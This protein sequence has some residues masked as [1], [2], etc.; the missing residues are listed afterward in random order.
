MKHG[1]WVQLVRAGHLPNVRCYTCGDLKKACYRRRFRSYPD[2][3][4]VIM[5]CHQ[6]LPTAFKEHPL[7]RPN[8][9]T[10][11]SWRD[12]N[13]LGMKLL[14]EERKRAETPLVEEPRLNAAQ[15]ELIRRMQQLYP[16]QPTD[17]RQCDTEDE[18]GSE[19]EEPA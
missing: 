7:Y 1:T 11:D 16:Q 3:V 4:F 18:V 2:I 15:L 8:V 5:P 14:E 12:Q 10:A 19:G 13:E 9:E 17:P 6:C